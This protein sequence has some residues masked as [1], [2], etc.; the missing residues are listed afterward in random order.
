[1]TG[2]GGFNQTGAPDPA[3]AKALAADFAAA[4]PFAHVVIDDFLTTEGRTAAEAFP[5]PDWPHWRRFF[6]QYQKEK[7]VCD[8]LA[9]IPRP[10]AELIGDC[11]GPR[12]LA[13]LETVTGIR[14]LLTDPY[15]DGGG[16]HC[17]GPGGVFWRRIRTFISTSG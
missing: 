1:M 6:D 14:G 16:L 13:F 7:R 10:L 15:L 3:R 4:K 9:A 8:D 11:G 5:P 2:A 12:F 17:S